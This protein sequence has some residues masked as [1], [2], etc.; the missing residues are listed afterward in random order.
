MSPYLALKL[1]YINK[2]NIHIHKVEL[3]T[4]YLNLSD[5]YRTAFSP[6]YLGDMLK[7]NKVLSFS[8]TVSQFMRVHKPKDEYKLAFRKNLKG[9]S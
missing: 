5:Y 3:K 7:T 9:A 8:R 1:G 4:L 6:S 2:S